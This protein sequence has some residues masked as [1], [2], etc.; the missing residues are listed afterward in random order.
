MEQTKTYPRVILRTAAIAVNEKK[1]QVIKIKF[2]FSNDDLIKVRTLSRRKYHGEQ[3]CWSCA[4]SNDNIQMLVEWGFM[5]DDKLK[6]MHTQHLQQTINN[7]C[8]IGEQT[9]NLTIPGLKGELRPFQKIGVAFAD[10]HDGNILNADDMG[11]GKTIQTIAYL[12]LRQK[13]MPVLIVVPAALKYNWVKEVTRWMSPVPVV[14]VLSGEKPY[15]ITGKIVIINYDI[16]IHW[17]KTIEKTRFN[18]LIADEVQNIKNSSAKRTKAFK[19]IQKKIPTFMALSGTPIENHPAELYNAINMIDPALFPTAWDFYWEFC[20]PKNNGYGW[21]YTG[22]TNIPKLHRILKSSIMMRRLK[23]D[24]LPELPDKT[25][26]FVPIELTN[27]RDYKNAETDFIAWVAKNKGAA[28]AEKAGNAA[29]LAEIEGLKQIAVHGKLKGAIAWITDFL[30]SGKKLVVVT[31]HTFVIDAIMQAF[32]GISLKLDGSTTGTKRQEVVDAF[33]TDPVYKLFVTNLKAG[34]VGITLTAAS[35]EVILELGWN[36]KIMDQVMDRI[37][38][39]G[40]KQAVNIY[41]LLA[42][43]TIEE[44]IAELLDKKRKMIDGVIDGIET[45]ESSL[46]K[47]LMKSYY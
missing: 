44:K 45:S 22:A 24:V 2:P 16:L 41:Y 5:L 7:N 26:S 34:G 25:I 21:T 30:E 4:L 20:D 38:R 15:T 1:E 47:E 10:A 12:Q 18:M 40:Q 43:G 33:Q 11:L 36:P 46:L 39:F 9:N 28:A 8:I 23:Q 17:Q 14:Q 31:T 37:H 32:P 42:L 6:E 35:D 27:Q 13:K 19:R 29:T 3:Q